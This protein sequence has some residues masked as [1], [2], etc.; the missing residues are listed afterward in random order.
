MRFFRKHDFN[1][2]ERSS[3]SVCGSV[4]AADMPVSELGIRIFTL[5]ELLIVIAII[6]VL[7]A[8]LLP[9]LNTAR[10]KAYQ[11][12]CLNNMRQIGLGFSQYITDYREYFPTSDAS[13]HWTTK[14]A[15]YSQGKVPGSSA[16]WRK[17]VYICPAD[18]HIPNCRR[19]TSDTDGVNEVRISYG[20]NVYLAQQKNSGGM[21]YEWPVRLS[22]ITRPSENLLVLCSEFLRNN[23]SYSTEKELDTAGHFVA[24][25]LEGSSWHSP[26]KS[27]V[28][29]VDG[30]VRLV[31]YLLLSDNTMQWRGDLPW[32]RWMKRD[33]ISHSY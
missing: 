3:Y 32:N 27:N 28:L 19:G 20:Y 17:S 22:V 11:V 15:P 24:S 5:I 25:R 7:A 18:R 1:F 33:P 13:P 8:I 16:A 23:P 21:T 10:N 2:S 6:A 12:K 30:G 29:M 31:P 4:S 9:A 14:T 26:S